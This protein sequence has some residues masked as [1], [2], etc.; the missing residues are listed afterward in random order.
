M[1]ARAK[2][3]VKLIFLSMFVACF[4]LLNT[5]CGLDEYY[6]LEEPIRDNYP[7]WLS[8]E[9]GVEYINRFF[10]FYTNE[11]SDYDGS[12]FEV[13]GTN[14]YYKI[15]SSLSTCTSDYSTLNTLVNSSSTKA[16]SASSLINSYNFKMLKI[17][18]DRSSSEVT[19]PHT[20][21]KRSQMVRIRLT[22]YL[23]D[24]TDKDLIASVRID[25][26]EVGVPIRYLNEQLYFDFKRDSVNYKAPVPVSDDKDTSGSANT[27]GYWYITLYAFCVG[28]DSTF[29]EYYSPIVHLGT[30]RIDANSYDN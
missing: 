23:E 2:H 22:T 26:A 30:L 4:I 19:I 21:S 25:D 1:K 6:V 13:S 17:D 27:D 12:G 8:D 7:V 15:Y 24:Q 3:T 16:S 5:G 14:V 18:G 9:T 28:H 10:R 11:N 29:T 20:T